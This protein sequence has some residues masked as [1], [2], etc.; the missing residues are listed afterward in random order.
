[1]EP[2]DGKQAPARTCQAE[3]EGLAHDR[4]QTITQNRGDAE[5]QDG[6]EAHTQ[7]RDEA[8]TQERIEANASMTHYETA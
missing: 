5:T 3:D 4:I 8:H 7:D 6:N 1:M 2:R